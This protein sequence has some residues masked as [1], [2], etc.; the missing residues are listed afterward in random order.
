MLLEG[1]NLIG[2]L[3]LEHFNSKISDSNVRTEALGHL[4]RVDTSCGG[5]THHHE[6]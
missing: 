2:T 6:L 1:D 4:G 3:L 5:W